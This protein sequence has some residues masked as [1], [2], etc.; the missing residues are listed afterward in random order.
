MSLCRVS[1]FIHDFAECDH[2]DQLMIQQTMLKKDQY[3]MLNI[4]MLCNYAECHYAECHIL[5]IV[6]LNVIMLIINDSTD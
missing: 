2:A 5:F 6:L 1:H 3:V 4:S